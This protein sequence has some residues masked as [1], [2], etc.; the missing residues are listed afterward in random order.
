MSSPKTDVFKNTPTDHKIHDLIKNRWSPRK[1]ADTPVSDTDLQSLFEAGRWAASSSNLQPWNIVWGKK[2]S[3]AYDRIMKVL[4]E[5]N[6]GWAKNAP[7][8]MLGVFDKKT[9]DGKD[10]FHALH[11]LG[12]FA[13][14]MSIQAQSMGIALH[15]MAGVKHEEAL[16]EF[17]FP[18]TY[19]VAT[20]IA[21]GYYGGEMSDLPED[22]KG[23]EKKER[24][25]KKQDEFIF[26]GDYV[27]RAEVDQS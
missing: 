6:Q 22:L 13:A 15:Q 19:H 17:K 8:L 2:G 5:F 1:F 14:N 10:N 11:D 24:Q 9:P 18:D 4:V 21:A 25:R 27:E 3:T 16:K 20:A 26:N 23:E 7:V 12:Q